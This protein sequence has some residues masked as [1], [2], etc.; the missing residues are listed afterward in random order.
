MLKQILIFKSRY[1]KKIKNLYFL[2]LLSFG[3]V[4]TH[5]DRTEKFTFS[6]KIGDLDS[7][8]V[9][10]EKLSV[11]GPSRDR[12]L[13]QLEEATIKRMKGD[14]DGSIR[15]FNK[16]SDEYARWFGAHLKT[17][18]KITEE[19][20]STL[21]SAEW[22]PYK[23]RIYER[24]MMR[25]Y[26]ALNY[27]QKGDDGRARA[28]IFKIRQAID[29]SKQI[30]NKELEIAQAEMNKKN[31]DLEKGLE[32]GNEEPIQS[33]ISRIKKIVPD[34]FPVFV[35]P[36]AIYL[37]ALYFLRGGKQRDDFEKAEFSLRQLTSIYPKNKWIEE[38][39]SKAKSFSQAT[40]EFTY[41]FFETGR[42]PVRLEKRFD[43]PVMF[44]S[45]T[46]R[47]PYL[48]IAMPSLKINDQYAS[49]INITFNSD[50][51]VYNT[52]LLADLD[53]IVSQEFEKF[54]P[55]EL[56]KAI[57]GSLLKGGLQYIATDS[58]R[59]END[60]V[61]SVLGVGSGILAQATTRADL[62]S[63]STLPKQIRFCK[64]STP[65]DK[66]LTIQSVGTNF[67]IAVTLK[68]SLTNLVFIRSISSYTPLKLVGQIS[69]DP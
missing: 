61:R 68:P 37:E 18:K 13:Y 5:Y 66:K 43:L 69:I 65:T 4:S 67:N 52:E 36:A 64:I 42:A 63:W 39:Y 3:C 33:D 34:N 15:S 6:W 10:A 20:L 19:F 29:D 60:T 38:D 28:E 30:W 16:V 31:I 41:I 32:S 22:K 8:S 59:G 25:Y 14:I 62:R 11:D 9:E 48:G 53:I 23:S 45:T 35:N 21:G 55:V 12:L 40:K 44:F 47:I 2:F 51:T 27:L 26:Q 46:S 49:N 56:T 58:V 50:N 57:S 1:L 54:Y 24:V 7:A 17:E